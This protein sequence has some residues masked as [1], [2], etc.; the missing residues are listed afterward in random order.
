M[1]WWWWW[2]WWRHNECDLCQSVSE[3]KDKLLSIKHAPSTVA[4][5]SRE[6]LGTEKN[7]Q[8][9]GSDRRL[10]FVSVV[11]NELTWTAGAAHTLLMLTYLYRP[12][13]RWQKVKKV[14]WNVTPGLYIPHYL[15]TDR[16][17]R[18]MRQVPMTLVAYRQVREMCMTSA[19]VLCP[20]LM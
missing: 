2:W 7:Q 14:R 18:H 3:L 4:Q 6:F 5:Y 17:D 15:Q 8:V 1:R 13:K 9:S 10:T 12:T 19:G 11:I 16:W 20:A